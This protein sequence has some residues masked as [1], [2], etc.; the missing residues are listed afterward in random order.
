VSEHLGKVVEGT[1]V[2]VGEKGEELGEACDVEKVK[3]VYKIGGDSAGKKGKKG[4]AVNGDGAEKKAEERRVMES[5][6]LGT[7]A[8]KGT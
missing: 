2:P 8:L 4:E 3:K 7:I 6:I 1:S 5:V